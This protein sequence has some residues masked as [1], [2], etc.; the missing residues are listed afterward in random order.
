MDEEEFYAAAAT[1]RVAATAAAESKIE[2][3]GAGAE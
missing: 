2:L 3:S 1:A